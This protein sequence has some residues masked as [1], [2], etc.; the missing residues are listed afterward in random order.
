MEEDCNFAA[1]TDS[2][3]YHIFLQQMRQDSFESIF[4]F[5]V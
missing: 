2:S 4:I 1:L 3:A 5:W